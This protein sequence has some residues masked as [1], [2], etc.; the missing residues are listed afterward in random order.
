VG[1]YEPG[2]FSWI[3]PPPGMSPGMARSESVEESLAFD[4]GPSAERIAFSNESSGR[5]AVAVSRSKWAEGD[6]S[7]GSGRRTG[8]GNLHFGHRTERPSA[9][10]LTRNAC[11]HSQRMSMKSELLLMIAS[12][13]YWSAWERKRWTRQKL[14]YHVSVDRR[15]S[16][17]LFRW[18]RKKPASWHRCGV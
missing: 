10:A 15:F 5:K 7:S 9:T 6:A 18:E 2:E 1:R 16:G 12:I 8:L 11:P 17:L 3:L 4:P 13:R 14:L